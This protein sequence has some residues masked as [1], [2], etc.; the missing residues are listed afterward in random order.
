MPTGPNTGHSYAPGAI[1]FTK[2]EL[3][4]V[5]D[6]AHRLGLKVTAHAI[7]A[8]SIQFALEAGV[9][10]IQHA[11][12]L[13]S[14]VIALFL[15]SH[16]GFINTYV[17]MMH[18]DSFTPRDWYFLDAEASTP[19]EWV[20]HVRTLVNEDIAKSQSLREDLKGR[21]AQLKLAKDKGIPIG[22]G[23]D[24]MHGL[25]DLEIEHLVN[26]GFTP[27]EAINAATGMTAK[28]LAIDKEV[29]T[30]ETGKYADIISIRGRPD[31]NIR[32]LGK[33][34]FVMVGGKN[35]SG[36]SFR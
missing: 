27:L 34:N 35:Y 22:V 11:S 32:D 23:T 6:E 26:A 1:N 16:A 4:A 14:E 29:G 3:D 28:V 17:T 20:D 2:D 9:D 24:D 15:K 10:S 36:L 8:Y 30:L 21:Y 33:V 18:A 19:Q 5:V 13:T 12:D 7:D 31:E 25:L